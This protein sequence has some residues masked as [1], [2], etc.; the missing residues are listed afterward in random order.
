VSS[1]RAPLPIANITVVHAEARLGRVLVAPLSGK[2]GD[3]ATVINL[4]GFTALI[5]IML[6]HSSV[7]LSAQTSDELTQANSCIKAGAAAVLTDRELKDYR[8]LKSELEAVLPNHMPT[9]AEDRLPKA[10]VT[11]TTAWGGIVQVKKNL[12][13]QISK[14]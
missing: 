13:D 9:P 5:G 10:V 14:F 11:G 4:S 1:Q 12:Q 6:A 7:G 2:G 8:S 3:H